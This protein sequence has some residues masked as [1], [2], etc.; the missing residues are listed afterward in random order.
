MA[1]VSHNLQFF[2]LL[3]LSEEGWGK[4]ASLET[5]E[6]LE[7][8]RNL[9]PSTSTINN[10]VVLVSRTLPVTLIGSHCF[11]FSPSLRIAG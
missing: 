7:P 1:I 4:V 8:T 9:L 3:T 10:S 2:S 11:D 6:P 5:W